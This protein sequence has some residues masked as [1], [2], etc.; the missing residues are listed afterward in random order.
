MWVQGPL[1]ALVPSTEVAAA[2]MVG[3]R[4]IAAAILE[5]S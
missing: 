3:W 2:I 1:L 4:W 5:S